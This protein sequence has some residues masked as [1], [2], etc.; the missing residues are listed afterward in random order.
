MPFSSWEK[1]GGGPVTFDEIQAFNPRG[2]PVSR[3][4]ARW[5]RRQ[6]IWP[7][8]VHALAINDDNE[9]F[10]VIVEDVRQRE[11]PLSNVDWDRDG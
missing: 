11:I 8:R 10:V 2:W 4:P 9:R 5:N 7:D 1:D 6:A 3:H